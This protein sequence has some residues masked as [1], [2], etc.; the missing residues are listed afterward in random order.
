MIKETKITI[1]N[2]NEERKKNG[3]KIKKG[4]KD[5][6]KSEFSEKEKLPNFSFFFRPTQTT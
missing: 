1:S 3:N 2:R 6:I 5:Q 4:H